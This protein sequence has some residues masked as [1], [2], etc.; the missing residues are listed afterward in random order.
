MRHP[1]F[2]SLPLA[3]SYIGIFILSGAA[4]PLCLDRMNS[5]SLYV[6]ALEGAVSGLLFCGISVFLWY[7]VKFTRLSGSGIFQSILNHI[8]LIALTTFVWLGTEYLLL[9]L[10]FSEQNFIELTNLIPFNIVIGVMGQ[11]I[12]IQYYSK[13]SCIQNKELEDE[14]E[15]TNEE[16][17]IIKIKKTIES[18]SVKN[19][20]NISILK[21]NDIIYIQAEGDYVMIFTNDK[22]YI[23]EET[24]KNLDEILPYFFVRIHRSCIV[25]SNYISRI[26]LYEKQNY[27]LTLKTGQQLKV[28]ISGYKLLKEKM[29]L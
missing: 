16:R 29:S 9:Y 25:N 22:K 5:L 21:V 27:R 28:S 13:I 20:S 26:E 7:V 17:P 10:F 4:I 15:E 1:K 6:L 18:I 12:L 24:M 11:I 8:A 2:T 14:L 3:I 19:N 23:K